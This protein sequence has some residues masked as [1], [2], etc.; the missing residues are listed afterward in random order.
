MSNFIDFLLVISKLQSP[1]Y[2]RYPQIVWQ[3]GS[4]FFG[5]SLFTTRGRHSSAIFRGNFASSL[6]RNCPLQ[7]LVPYTFM[8]LK[9]T[10]V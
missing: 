4:A 2:R 5:L 10:R 8:T 9:N 3:T 7:Y 1:I 6:T